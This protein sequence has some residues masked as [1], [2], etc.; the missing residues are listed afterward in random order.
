MHTVK[1]KKHFNRHSEK[2]GER[3][4]EHRGDDGHC[5]VRL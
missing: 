4:R 5:S 2:E 3:E 1:K